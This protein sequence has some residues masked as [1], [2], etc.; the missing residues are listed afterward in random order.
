ML[1][2]IDADCKR[3]DIPAGHAVISPGGLDKVENLGTAPVQFNVTF[4]LPHGVKPDIDQT[5]PAGCT[6]SPRARARGIGRDR[7]SEGRRRIEPGVKRGDLTGTY[8]NPKLTTAHTLPPSSSRRRKNDADGSSATIP[9]VSPT[10]LEAAPR[11]QPNSRFSRCTRRVLPR[12][13]AWW[14][15]RTSNWREAWSVT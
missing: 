14:L 15:R 13:S 7:R 10:L 11:T 12:D 9:S 8:P 6:A 5:P 4:L 3:H 2:V 1:T